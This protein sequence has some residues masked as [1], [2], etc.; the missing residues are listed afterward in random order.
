MLAAFAYRPPDATLM[1]ARFV[2]QTAAGGE[3]RS[4]I[5]AQAH[6]DFAAGGWRFVDGIAIERSPDG[7]DTVSPLASEG[8][9]VETPIL[10]SDVEASIESP[11][12]LSADQLRTQLRRTPSFRHLETLI[13][14]RYTQC[15]AGVALVL[16]TLPIALG[17]IRGG[18]YLRVLTGLGL[19]VAY[20]LL[21]TSLRELGNRGAIEPVTAA[22]LPLALFGLIGIVSF[23][24]QE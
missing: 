5:G 6:Y 2:V 3:A 4:V 22:L 23:V 21:T 17:G 9:L 12:F 11:I 24:L 14:E 13:Y 19:G 10:P 1:N 20:F 7:V 18:L 16:A 15:L 8:L